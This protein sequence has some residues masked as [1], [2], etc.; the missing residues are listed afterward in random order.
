M[1]TYKVMMAALVLVAVMFVGG[2]GNSHSTIFPRLG[3]ETHM[4]AYFD[5]GA[6]DSTNV[7]TGNPE[8]LTTAVGK[9]VHSPELAP[10]PRSAV[11]SDGSNLACRAE[12]AMGM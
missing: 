10:L 4:R 3:I 2:C 11:T 5:G 9:Q 6:T 1:R 8:V 12:K 7:V